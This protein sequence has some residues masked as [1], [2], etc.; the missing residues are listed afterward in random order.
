M[1]KIPN[2][3]GL[4]LTEVKVKDGEEVPCGIYSRGGSINL[5]GYDVQYIG[6]TP[7]RL[8]HFWL[9]PGNFQSLNEEQLRS[10]GFILKDFL[11]GKR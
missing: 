8:A 7:D 4:Q 1:A 3:I 10:Q 6:V 9:G 11:E 5:Y 2:T